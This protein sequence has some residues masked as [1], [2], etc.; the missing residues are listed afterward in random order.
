[1]SHIF[2]IWNSKQVDN[3][4]NIGATF[5]GLYLLIEMSHIFQ[6]WNS[7]QVDNTDHI[8]IFFN[9]LLTRI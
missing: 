4:D 5:T 3:T 7:E 1:M 2:Q 8:D 9:I 6:I